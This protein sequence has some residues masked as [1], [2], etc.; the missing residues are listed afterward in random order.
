[1]PLL[2]LLSLLSSTVDFLMGAV[3]GGTNMRLLTL[4]FH[5]Q[6]GLVVVELGPKRLDLPGLLIALVLQAIALLHQIGTQ[7]MAVLQLRFGRDS[8]NFRK[9]S[10]KPLRLQG[11]FD[12]FGHGAFI[13]LQV[14]RV[15]T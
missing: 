3:L 13:P 10:N 14:Q 8:G 1:V 4:T 11:K 9:M 15:V 2:P 7:C 6:R 12:V 5:S